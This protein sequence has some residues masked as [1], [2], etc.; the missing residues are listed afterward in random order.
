MQNIQFG[1]KADLTDA[2]RSIPRWKLVQG[3]LPFVMHCAASILYN[4]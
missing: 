1:L 4:R 2:I 3:A